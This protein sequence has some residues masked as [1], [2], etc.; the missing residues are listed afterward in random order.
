MI[1]NKN[2]STIFRHQ[3]NS[4]TWRSGKWK[5]S[6][7]RYVRTI[8]VSWSIASELLKVI[9]RLIDCKPYWCL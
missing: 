7:I 8:L 9:A 2:G 3:L 1:I 4:S 6:K 5:S